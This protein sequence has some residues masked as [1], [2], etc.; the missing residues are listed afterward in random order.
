M[1]EKGRLFLCATPIGN[2]KDI[3]LRVLETLNNVDLIA[4]EDTRQTLKLLNHFEIK[5]PVTSYFEHNKQFKGEEIIEE[6]LAGKDVALVSDAG[7]PGVSDPGYELV[8]ECI[9]KGIEVTALPGPV[10]AITG[11]VLS[12]LDTRRFCFEGF[13]PRT[14]KDKRQFFQ[15]LINEERTIVF[16]ESPHR[17]LET[18]EVIREVWGSKRRIAVCRELTKMFEEVKRGTVDEVLNYFREQKI[19]GEFTLIIE[20]AQPVKV[21]RGLDWARNRVK[22]LVEEGLTNKEAVKLAAKEADISKRVLYEE[23]MIK[24]DNHE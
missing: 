15:N 3:T 23:I 2:L 6:L 9:K 4:C 19:K 11:L 20:G 21:E 17:L 24:K 16:Y 8:V 18:L 7:M 14:K 1:T 5:K 13:I 10:A 22:E 12:G